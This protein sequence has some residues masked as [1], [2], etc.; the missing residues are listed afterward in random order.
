MAER[1]AAVGG[2]LTTGNA[3]QGGFRVTAR[4]PA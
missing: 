4:L 2:R 1:V 3:P